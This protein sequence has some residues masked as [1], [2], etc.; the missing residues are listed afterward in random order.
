VDERTLHKDLSTQLP[1]RPLG[2][3]IELGQR[4]VRVP[5][6]Q[7]DQDQAQTRLGRTKIE[8]PRLGDGN[9]AS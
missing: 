2:R 1:G 9:R 3:T 7:Q 5:G 6:L 8:I 4:R